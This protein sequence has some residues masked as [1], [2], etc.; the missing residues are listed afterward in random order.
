[1]NRQTT[2][3]DVGT[4]RPLFRI[5]PRSARLDAYPYDVR[6]DGQR[7]L[8]NTIIEEVTPPISLIV[9]WKPKG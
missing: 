8:F 5:E 1:V 6:R 7:F 2:R 9:N 3:F 4:S